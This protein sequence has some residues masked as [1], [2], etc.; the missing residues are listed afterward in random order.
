[1]R[2]KYYNFLREHNLPDILHD[3]P[4]MSYSQKIKVIERLRADYVDGIVRLG[5]NQYHQNYIK[6]KRVRLDIIFNTL[7]GI[8]ERLIK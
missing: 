8:C 4:E 3:I 1:M 2:D 7:K 6:K 5:L